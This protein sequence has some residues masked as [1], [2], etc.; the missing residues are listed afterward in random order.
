MMEKLN[1]PWYFNCSILVINAKNKQFALQMRCKAFIC[2]SRAVRD[3]LT[4][5]ARGKGGYCGVGQCDKSRTL[6][7]DALT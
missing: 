6:H 3:V 7:A 1:F 2:A 5:A 4:H